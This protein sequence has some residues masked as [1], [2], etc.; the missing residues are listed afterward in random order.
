MT[1]S[2]GS[3]STLAT[4][5]VLFGLAGS[6]MAVTVPHLFSGAEAPGFTL[7]L[8]A[9]SAVIALTAGLFVI[10]P[11]WA[12]GSAGRPWCWRPATTP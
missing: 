7:F 10:S 1:T 6:A 8:V 12:W 3:F 5:L 9:G 11:A 4:A 2:A